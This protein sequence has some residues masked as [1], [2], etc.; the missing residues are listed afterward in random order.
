MAKAKSTI[1]ECDMAGFFKVALIAEHYT[2]QIVNVLHYRSTDWLW[3]DGNPFDD[4]QNTLNAVVDHIQAA[5]VGCHNMDTRLL[6]AEAVGY[7]DNYNIVTSSPLVKT[8]NVTGNISQLETTG[9]YQSANIGL[10][11]GE[12]VQINGTGK[13]KRN[14]GYLSIGPITESSI[15]AT[16]VLLL[17]TTA[18]LETFAQKLDDS[19][20]VLVPSVTLIPIRIHEKWQRLPAPLPDVLLWR[21]YSDVKG[22]TLPRFGAVRRSRM[23]HG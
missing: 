4:V 14:R 18:V 21:T 6:R 23:A 9:S 3:N 15:D 19:I 22:Y 8:I 16:G 2:N 20:V 5:W 12:Q 13:S 7:D 1:G 17:S 10:R 11:C